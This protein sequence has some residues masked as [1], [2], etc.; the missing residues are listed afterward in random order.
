MKL[1]RVGVSRR[2]VGL[3]L[4]H[5]SIK[6]IEL[7]SDRLTRWAMIDLPRGTIHNG[8]IRDIPTVAVHMRRALAVAK[9]A[10]RTVH[11]AVSG[12]ACFIRRLTLPDLSPRE[13]HRIVRWEAERLLPYPFA[14]SVV[15]YR[16]LGASGN[17]REGR[18]ELLIVAVRAEIVQQYAA[19]AEAAGLRIA[20]LDVK[21]LVRLRACRRYFQPPGV[22]LIG[23]GSQSI[24]F[25]GVDELGLAFT[26]TVP[27]GADTSAERSSVMPHESTDHEG[28]DRG[29]LSLVAEV[30]RSIRFFEEQ[31]QKDV[32]AIILSGGG[33]EDPRVLPALRGLGGPS[34]VGADP[35][36]DLEAASA[37][38]PRSPRLCV[39]MGLASR[40]LPEPATVEIRR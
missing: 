14:E 20:T 39:A 24:E 27:T 15:D 16:V 35:L 29:V 19:A 7:E 9:V 31:T 32:A 26:R 22:L 8:I 38:A 6:I 28:A 1:R 2:V 25:T 10:A 5:S 3:D 23:L 33:A 18:L 34:V 4:G 36:T 40:G 13:L 21:P 30:V 37:T 17:R 11:M 12:A